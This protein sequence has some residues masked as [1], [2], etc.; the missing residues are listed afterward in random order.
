MHIL[1][2]LSQQ[3]GIME[4]FKM[5]GTQI[6]L[7]AVL[8]ANLNSVAVP[9]SELVKSTPVIPTNKFLFLIHNSVRINLRLK[10]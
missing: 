7:E 6:E 1:L 5:A 8:G 2:G 9:L 10:N 3:E 4:K